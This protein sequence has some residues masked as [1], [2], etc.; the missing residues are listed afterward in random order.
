MRAL[1]TP[2]LHERFCSAPVLVP[3]TAADPGTTL[4]SWTFSVHTLKFM[5][6][7]KRDVTT[8]V[9]RKAFVVRQVA[10][11]PNCFLLTLLFSNSPIPISVY[12]LSFLP[13]SASASPSWKFS[14]CTAHS[15]TLFSFIKRAR[16]HQPPLSPP[17]ILLISSIR[18]RR[19]LF[20][21]I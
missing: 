10:C 3:G 21:S 9:Q 5:T 12:R 20:F 15:L 8:M 16:N 11:N 6:W 7:A 14:A 18:R 19:L 1:V 2:R 13:D 4:L 17:P